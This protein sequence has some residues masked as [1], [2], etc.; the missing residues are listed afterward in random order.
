MRGVLAGALMFIATTAFIGVVVQLPRDVSATDRFWSAF[1]VDG[2][3]AAHFN[4][5]EEVYAASDLVIVGEVHRVELSRQWQATE[6]LGADGLAT[7]VASFVLPSATLKNA[8]QAVAD[9]F[10]R[11][12]MFLPS[13]RDL[14]TV[15]AAPPTGQSIYFLVAIEAV[16]NTYRLVSSQGLLRDLGGAVGVSTAEDAWLAGLAETSFNDLVTTLRGWDKTTR[17]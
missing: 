13:A 6:D 12:E 7:F 5:L 4:S 3:E 14:D 15:L 2:V 1:H 10:T 8:G 16:P 11:V 9:E 17:D